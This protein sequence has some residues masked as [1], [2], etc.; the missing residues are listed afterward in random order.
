ME[1]EEAV[2]GGL[3]LERSLLRRVCTV[4]PGAPL[5]A[6]PPPA[7]PPFFVLCCC[8]WCCRSISMG[9]RTIF[10]LLS[11][12]RAVSPP[13]PPLRTTFRAIRPDGDE[14]EEVPLGVEGP[15]L[16]SP[17]RRGLSTADPLLWLP[18]CWSRLLWMGICRTEEP[19][20]ELALLLLLPPTLVLFVWSADASASLLSLLLSSLASS[21]LVTGSEARVKE[22]SLWRSTPSPWPQSL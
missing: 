14:E 1:A 5:A 19:E 3:I 10:P 21:A 18:P 17:P 12:T 13:A 20:E 8:A 16:L 22:C 2:E 11:L 9:T 15:E 6:V 4:R 7:S